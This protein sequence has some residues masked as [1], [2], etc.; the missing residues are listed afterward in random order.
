MNRNGSEYGPILQRLSERKSDENSLI[1][2]K[3][4]ILQM[5]VYS[6]N[7]IHLDRRMDENKDDEGH[8]SIYILAIIVHED[9][10]EVIS[11]FVSKGGRSEAPLVLCSQ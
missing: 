8:K 1:Q 9:L 2:R 4:L 6:K 7:V 3:F 10:H 11:G 5:Y